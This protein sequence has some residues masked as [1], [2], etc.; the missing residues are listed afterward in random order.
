MLDTITHAI[1]QKYKLHDV[2]GVFLSAFDAKGNLLV[3]QG[4]LETDQPLEAIIPAL[5]EK[6]IAPGI[7]TTQVVTI[8]V[9]TSLYEETDVTKITAIAPNLYGFAL[10]D[11]HGVMGTILPNTV[12]VA[13]AKH[14]LFLIKQKHTLGGKVKIFVFTTERLLAMK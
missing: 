8:D 1:E 7:A 11:E 5:Y 4:M 3:S 14:A 6:H 9:V 13:D 10:V 12:G 2:K